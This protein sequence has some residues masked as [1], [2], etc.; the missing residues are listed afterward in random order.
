MEVLC[1]VASLGESVRSLVGQEPLLDASYK[2]FSYKGCWAHRLELM[3]C[4]MVPCGNKPSKMLTLWKPP[5]GRKTEEM[6]CVR[7][8]CSNVP[9]VQVRG[10]SVLEALRQPPGGGMS[11]QCRLTTYIASPR[12]W[13][14]SN[15]YVSLGVLKAPHKSG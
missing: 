4:Q 3:V 7:N 1:L 8:K 15:A 14:I 9:Q 12:S 2:C 13:T 10:I 11:W 5:P 6:V